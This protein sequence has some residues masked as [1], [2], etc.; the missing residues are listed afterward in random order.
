MLLESTN[1]NRILVA[2]E[3]LYGKKLEKKLEDSMTKGNL[4]LL[5]TN[6]DSLK[7]LDKAFLMKRYEWK[8]HEGLLQEFKNET[9]MLK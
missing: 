3:F 4:N 9:E 5:E 8:T 2:S 7:P 1:Y 6:S